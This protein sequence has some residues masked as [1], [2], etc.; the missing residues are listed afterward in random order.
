MLPDNQNKHKKESGSGKSPQRFQPKVLIIYLVI[1]AGVLTL[2]FANSSA[3]SG[4]K[5]LTINEL[6]SLVESGA[7]QA[8]AGYMEPDPSYGRDGYVI[9]GNIPNPAFIADDL[10]ATET[11]SVRFVARGRLTEVDF[12]AVRAVFNEKRT[13]TAMQDVLISILP[14][15]LIIGLLYFLF[16]RQLKSAGRGAMSFGKSKAKM[17]TR[18]KDS[19]NFKNVA[20]C[21]EA[22][23]EVSE[24]VDFLK[25]PKK[26]QKIGGRIPKGVL[27][28][29]PPGTGKTLLAKAVAGE[30][31]VPFF[32]IS[33]SDFV[34][35]F[36]GV[37]AARVRDMFEQGRKNAPCI[38]F[39]DEI[40][41][42]GRQRGA[43]VGGGN[44]EREQTLNSL[45]VEMD[46][47]DGHEGVIIIA[48]T[49]RPDVLDSALLRPGRFDR[50]VTI[51][52]P[53]INGRQ[54]ILAVHAKRIALSEEVN[55]E[56]VARN[57]PGFSGADL[58]NLLNEGALIAARYN[59][60]VVEMND[61]DEARDKISFG[62]ERRKLMDDE[63]RKITAY[64]EAGH[65]LVQA[66]IDDGHMP[67]HKVTIIPR[68]QSLGST[69]FMPKKDILNHSKRRLLNQI[70]CG[71]GGR[72][73]EEIVNGDQ[74][75]GASGDIRMVTSVARHMVCEWGMSELGPIAYG[76]SQSHAYMG[77]MASGAKDYSEA[78]AQRID[79]IILEIVEEQ[80]A[81][82]MQLLNEHRTAL[83]LTAEAL[84]EHETID[85]IHVKEII[86]FGEMR[87]PI[88]KRSLDAPEDEDDISQDALA[89]DKKPD[90]GPDN[91]LA[92]GGVTAGAPA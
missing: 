31:E 71:L 40:D 85:G 56:H 81:R 79:K 73:A 1:L 87:S 91:G 34:E 44:D 16:V 89:E 72:G 86:E 6:V 77:Q 22:K 68:G 51:D 92:Q 41:A 84:L 63:D 30:A 33:G 42:V 32:S 59:K 46:G 78:T 38:V 8:G 11:E 43:G 12:L 17:L 20:G 88:V 21:D 53:D 62:R 55:L 13:S 24:V 75:S 14:F 10:Q 15:L 35:M 64:H 58:S 36:V 4:V 90:E 66:L 65:A 69:M 29:G 52:L 28:V 76:D 23:E 19:V 3:N 18:G 7:L 47:F 37:G 27:M 60:Q 70:C 49:N 54:E 2:W 25:D 82:C 83:D 80:Q 67:V 50:Q 61:L 74:T 39:I 5:Q 9:S 26:F 57:T 45:L 48:A